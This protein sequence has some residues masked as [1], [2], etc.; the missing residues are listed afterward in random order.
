MIELMNFLGQNSLIIFTGIGLVIAGLA[1]AFKKTKGLLYAVHVILV[2]FLFNMFYPPITPCSYSVPEQALTS[3][4]SLGAWSFESSVCKLYVSNF[5]NITLASF[6]LPHPVI[7]YIA[8]IL[9]LLTVI[10]ASISLKFS[11]FW[12]PTVYI[13]V[14]S[15]LTSYL[16]RDMMI[17]EFYFTTATIWTYMFIP[18]LLGVIIG[19]TSPFGGEK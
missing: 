13:I 11:K 17:E 3:T 1:I 15:I 6:Q 10:F 9:I 14:F 7:Y 4:S 19:L 8:P 12:L 16:T 18:A 5:P 2:G